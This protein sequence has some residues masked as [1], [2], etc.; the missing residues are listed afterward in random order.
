MEPFCIPWSCVDL[1]PK[2]LIPP[3]T[4]N[5]QSKTLKSFAQAVTN[6]C[7]I[8]LSQLPQACVKGDRLA[9]GIPE[10]DY[11]AGIDAC[12]Y[13]LHGRIIWPK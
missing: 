3:I 11:M 13:N 4:E 5:T 1:S 2:P 10:E 8:P 9:I 7:E 12:K 6:V